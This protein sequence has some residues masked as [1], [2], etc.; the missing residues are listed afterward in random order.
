MELWQR[1]LYYLS[2]SIINNFNNWRNINP[3][4]LLYEID[5]LKEEK[6]SGNPERCCFFDFSIYTKIYTEGKLNKNYE[7]ENSNSTIDSSSS[8]ILNLKFNQ[9]GKFIIKSLLSIRPDQ[10]IMISLSIKSN[11]NI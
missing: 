6:D 9:Y 4:G 3:D 11:K 5:T 1:K 8:D 2:N 7:I 10:F